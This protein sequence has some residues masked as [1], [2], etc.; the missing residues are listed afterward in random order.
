MGKKKKKGVKRQM[1][2][3]LSSK[4]GFLFVLDMTVQQFKQIKTKGGGHYEKEIK[5]LEEAHS[6]L[7]THLAVFEI[8]KN[9]IDA[10]SV[11]WS[12]WK[13][14]DNKTE[15]IEE[16]TEEYLNSQIII[17][18]I[19]N[20]LGLKRAGGTSAP[21]RTSGHLTDQILKPGKNF[22]EQ[23]TIFDQLR[24]ETKAD[25]KKHDIERDETIEGIQLSAYEKKLV[26]SLCKILHD[27][28]QTVDPQKRDFYTGEGNE[29]RKY[30]NSGDNEVIPRLYV[31]LFELTKEYSGKNTPSGKDIQNTLKILE[32]LNDRKFLIRYRET[33]YKEKGRKTVK[34]IE[35]VRPLLYVDKAIL[36]DFDA[37]GEEE[38]RSEKIV[39]QLNPIF[40]RHIDR[41]FIVY[42]GD[43]QKRMIEAYG[44]RRVSECAINLR[45]Y[46][47]REVSNKRYTPEIG[48][49]KALKQF[50]PKSMKSNRKKNAKRNLE[51]A[52]ETAQ[53]LHLVKSHKVVKGATGEDKIV[54]ELNK[55][56][57]N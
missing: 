42:P 9:G 25:L 56:W 55:N 49:T 41:K 10:G 52:I 36:R 24:T 57:I 39:I 43:I 3:S 44:N 30:L 21:F 20:A 32:D 16:K 35:G 29:I 11:K 34:E 2:I 13:D 17:T 28:S 37:K 8:K 47:A 26:D 19:A 1:K 23:L 18:I 40:R 22:A 53:N 54:F 51:K 4:D 27:N 15:Q 48:Y 6:F 46:L 50:D 33:E 7:S 12:V 38:Y 45:D 5:Y 14:E 31:T